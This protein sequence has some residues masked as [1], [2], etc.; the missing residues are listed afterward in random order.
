[1]DDGLDWLPDD[2]VALSR[3]ELERI[4]SNVRALIRG[5]ERLDPSRA[6]AVDIAFT[7]TRAIDRQIGDG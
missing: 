7:L 1:M 6:D 4:F 3:A 5:T 2:G